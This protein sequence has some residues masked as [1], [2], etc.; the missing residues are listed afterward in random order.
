MGNPGRPVW[1]YHK[2]TLS[3]LSGAFPMRMSLFALLVVVLIGVRSPLVNTVSAQATSAASPVVADCTVQ[4]R[5][6][7]ELNEIASTAG[8]PVSVTPTS[9]EAIP[10]VK[11]LGPAAS[12]QTVEEVMETVGQFYACV[13]AG[14]FL[15]YA[16]LF[17]DDLIRSFADETSFLFPEDELLTPSPIPAEDRVVVDE[18]TDVIE[19]SDGRISAL[20]TFSIPDADQPFWLVITLSYD[21]DRERW[22]I[23]DFREVVKQE[24][25]TPWTLVQG[26]GYVGV[27]VP[28]VSAAELTNAYVGGPV[29][30][31]WFPTE[32]EIAALEQNLPAYLQTASAVTRGVGEDFINRL[33]EYKRQYA[34]FIQDGRRLILVNASCA[35]D[36]DWATQPL[37]VQDG[38]DCFFRVTY[39]PESGS[40]EH[41]EVNGEA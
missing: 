15:R 20:A 39:E 22:L 36:L 12:A 40:F 8:T 32:T 31:L 17:S 35:E 5:T 41:F 26:E 19:L 7:G 30:E 25:S 27:I 10:Y 24:G 6:I 29:Q 9:D 34:G 38:G 2:D 28:P 18:I 4:P 37:I 14:D 1:A 23:D 3:G 11:P 16:A 21:Q 13:N 33:P